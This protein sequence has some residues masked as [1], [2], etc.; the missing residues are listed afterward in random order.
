MLAYSLLLALALA[1][2]SPWWMLRMFTTQ[3]YREGL[4]QRLGSVPASLLQ[5][6]TGQRVVWIH[7]VSVGEVSAAS[8]LAGEL[9]AALGESW[10]VVI[11]TTT[12]TGQTLARQRFGRE[13]VFYYP[14]DFA[15][16]VR[17]YLNVLKPKAL[18]LMESELW[19]RM[20]AECNRRNIPIVVANARISDRSFSRGQRAKFLWSRLLG[21]VTLWL[22]QSDEDARRLIAM[23]ARSSSVQVS[24]NLKYDVRAP[25]HSRI[26]ELI[27]EAAQDRPIIV[28][29][30]TVD[31]LA[32]RELSEDERV[33]QAWEGQPRQKFDALLVVAP[34]HP[35]RFDEVEAVVREFPYVRASR[36]TTPSGTGRPALVLLDTIGDLAAVYGIAHIAFVGGSLVSRG[37]HNPLEPAQFAVPVVMGSSYE[38]F[39]D[40]AAKMLAA[41]ALRIVNDTAEL[42]AA[43]EQLLADRASASALGE[44][45]RKVFEQQQGATARTVSAIVELLAGARP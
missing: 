23:G 41:D 8:R 5:S 42:S 31:R 33:I 45:G 20:L 17:S 12:R 15:F 9:E 38:N 3:R 27:R 18:V 34:R 6:V 22:A 1:L 2:S 10:V 25:Q 43:F 37:G 24:G 29:G 26:A 13:R 14:L 40:I 36:W 4:R 21:K 32:D 16:A 30:S 11:S 39:R 28:A 35:E 7:A 19:P 44:R